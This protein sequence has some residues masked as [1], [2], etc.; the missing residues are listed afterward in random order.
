MAE[1]TGVDETEDDRAWS[2]PAT[3]STDQRIDWEQARQYAKNATAVRHLGRRTEAL[4]K[5]FESV[6]KPIVDEDVAWTT[7]KRQIADTLWNSGVGPV[8]TGPSLVALIVVVGLAIVAQQC[9]VDPIE[10]SKELRGWKNGECVVEENPASPAP[11]IPPE[12][13]G[14]RN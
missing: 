9:G 5:L 13:E 8:K 11:S 1:E 6:V 12:P 10:L 14:T 3:L 7:L 4:E 2:P